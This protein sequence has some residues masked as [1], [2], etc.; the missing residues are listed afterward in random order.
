VHV[1]PEDSRPKGFAHIEFSSP[2][3]AA[4]AVSELNGQEIEGRRLRL[5]VA[6]PRGSG[7]GSRACF[8]CNEEGHMARE[9]PNADAGG[10]RGGGN[11]CFKCKEEGHKSFECP[12]ASTAGAGGGGGG[13][14]C[15]KCGEEGHMSRECPKAGE[16]SGGGGRGNAVEGAKIFVG[17][18]SFRSTEDTVREFFA[19][20][21]TITSCNVPMNEDGDKPKG[22]AHIE[23][24]S[25]EEA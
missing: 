1:N 23:F 14:A 11:A 19:S 21:G 4:K 25:A 9:C 10:S 16:S 5:D 3:E 6:K 17:G 20:A 13:R 8:K 24:T 12:N 15:F 7:G 18:L 22:F 2:E